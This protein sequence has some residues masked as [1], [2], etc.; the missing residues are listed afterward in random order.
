MAAL[1]P[2]VERMLILL[3]GDVDTTY[4]HSVTEN[5]DMRSSIGVY[6]QAQDVGYQNGSLLYPS[7]YNGEFFP[8]T[9]DPRYTLYQGIA[10][11]LDLIENY[12]V[13]TGGP[14]V[15]V[16]NLA[17]GNSP[18]NPIGGSTPSNPGVPAAQPIADWRANP[19]DGLGGIHT[20]GTLPTTQGVS[21]HSLQDVPVY[22]IG[23]CAS[24][25]SGSYANVD[26]YFAM[27]QCLGL[28]RSSGSPMGSNSTG[29]TNSTSSMSK[30]SSSSNKSSSS[31]SK[32]SSGTAP[33]PYSSS[34]SSSGSSSKS[35]SVSSSVS[36][37]SS[38]S[39]ASAS[40]YTTTAP[41]AYK[42]GCGQ[43]GKCGGWYGDNGGLAPWA[44][45]AQGRYC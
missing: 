40:A 28:S 39:S 35:S 41:N 10:A 16:I 23:P 25:F 7:G 13:H 31:S 33:A 14:R 17:G 44:Q 37:S 38:A 1:A 26:I 9:W 19:A 30:S 45:G 24:M 29:G 18:A 21:V 22:A 12:S 2:L 32:S 3:S 43:L 11:D 36:M 5:S 34:A 4:L 20:N 42:Q 6:T 15:P 27:A 8:G